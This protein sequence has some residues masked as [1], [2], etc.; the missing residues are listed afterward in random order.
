[1]SFFFICSISFRVLHNTRNPPAYPP[2]AEGRQD[3]A[4]IF[5]MQRATIFKLL[6]NNQKRYTL[7]CGCCFKYTAKN[8]NY[9]VV[10]CGFY[11]SGGG[12]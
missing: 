4:F 8:E 10:V 2:Q 7:C 6:N 5:L 11:I 12:G 3:I 9:P 1:M